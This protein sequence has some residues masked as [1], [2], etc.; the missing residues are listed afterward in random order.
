[1]D[2]YMCIYTIGMAVLG[3][4]ANI[5]IWAESAGDIR[6]FESVKTILLGIIVG[7]VYYSLRIEHNF[8]DGVA[9]F[10]IGYMAK[11]ALDAIAQRFYPLKS[12]NNGDGNG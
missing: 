2:V 1:M 9:S 5:L 4:L 8:P 3:A 6:R 12:N 10:A 7:I 11:D